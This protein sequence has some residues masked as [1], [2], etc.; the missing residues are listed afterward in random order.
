MA[1]LPNPP[2]A[3]VVWLGVR[4][5]GLWGCGVLIGL[6]VELCGCSGRV[7]VCYREH[8][9]AAVGELA[10]VAGLDVGRWTLDAG[11]AAIFDATHAR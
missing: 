8:D 2:I 9:A 6:G 3:A 11:S 5:E 1:D 7:V 10:A 4:V